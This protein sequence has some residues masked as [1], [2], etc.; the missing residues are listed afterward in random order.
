MPTSVLMP[1]LPSRKKNNVPCNSGRLRYSTDRRA[2]SAIASVDRT[3]ERRTRR[4]VEEEFRA[5]ER[6][7]EGEIWVSGGVRT[8]EGGHGMLRVRYRTELHFH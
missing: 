1:K 8:E 2:A 5:S 3:I 4:G 6:K 7:R